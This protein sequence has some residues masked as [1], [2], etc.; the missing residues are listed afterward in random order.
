MQRPI[1]LAVFCL[2]LARIAA[3]Q[4]P[5]GQA[6]GLAPLTPQKHYNG[7]VAGEEAYLGNDA[8]REAEIGRQATLNADMY[9]RWSGASS[10]S[11]GVFEAWPIVPGEIFGWPAAISPPRIS[12]T[13]VR[14]SPIAPDMAGPAPVARRRLGPIAVPPRPQLAQPAMAA[15]AGDLS[16]GL[17]PGFVPQGEAT[18]S[19]SKPEAAGRD[20]LPKPSNGPR[21][22]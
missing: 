15:A 20:R 16:P 21:A 14:P 6:Q 12:P 19:V 18:A 13:S 5:S 11:P 7:I 1:L 8:R 4:P 3:A 2:C 22:F 17:L 10:W 9:W